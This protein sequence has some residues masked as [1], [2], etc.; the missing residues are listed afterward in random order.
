[1]RAHRWW[2]TTVG[3]LWVLKRLVKLKADSWHAKA[4]QQGVHQRPRVIARPRVD[5]HPSPLV[6]DDQVAVLMDDLQ[7]QVLCIVLFLH[8][9]LRCCMPRVRQWACPSVCGLRES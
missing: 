1:M 2:C 4:V 7:R 8:Q 5:H 9:L 6:E 3:E